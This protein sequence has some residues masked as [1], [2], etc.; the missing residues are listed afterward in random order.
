MNLHKKKLKKENI[1]N[2]DK[3]INLFNENKFKIN[4]INI[5]NH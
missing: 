3:R 1:T 4:M 2:E 5:Q